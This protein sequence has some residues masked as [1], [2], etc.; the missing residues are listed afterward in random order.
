ML[1]PEQL[2]VAR[3]D[4]R[5]RLAKGVLHEPVSSYALE[6]HLRDDTERSEPDAHE[7]YSGYDGPM[8]WEWQFE[9]CD[10][11]APDAPSECACVPSNNDQVWMEQ[12]GG[13]CVEQAD[14]WCS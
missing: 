4:P 3:L 10:A 9:N 14:D 7:M 5:A 2:L 8:T 13:G 6:R 12:S 1:V 11:G